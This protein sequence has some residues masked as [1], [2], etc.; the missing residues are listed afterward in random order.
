MMKYFATGLLLMA[1]GTIFAQTDTTTV[2]DDEEIV[3]EMNVGTPDRDR[4]VFSLH[5]DGLLGAPDSMDVGP[6]SRGVGLHFYY[7]IPFDAAKQYSFAVGLGWNN[8]NYYTKSLLV[9]DSLGNTNIVGFNESQSVTRNKL[10]VHYVEV[11]VEFRFRTKPNQKGNSFKVAVGFKGGYQFSNHTKYVG[12]EYL[13]DDAN[14]VTL[15]DNANEIKY[16]F[17]RYS[18]LSSVQYGPTL[19]IG[20]ANVNLE[21]FYGMAGLFQEGKGPAGTPLQIGVSFNPF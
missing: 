15:V 9:N 8:A 12:D 19:R 5:W 17:Y 10:A 7:D 2:V 16:K 18:S 1:G 6:L 14:N 11:P 21:A 13:I 20:Y 4:F 3:N